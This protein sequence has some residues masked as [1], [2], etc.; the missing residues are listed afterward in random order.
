MRVTVTVEDHT[1]Q[2][3]AAI[4][5]ARTS[6]LMDAGEHL[7]QA[8]SHTIPLEEGVMMGSGVVASDGDGTVAV[9]YTDHPPKLLR[10]HEDVTLNHAPGRRA[11]WLELAGQEQHAAMQAH[12]VD[13]L[14][15]AA[16]GG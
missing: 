5:S 7:L 16:G 8:A 9:G 2:V 3:L 6:S 14:R 15:S 13:A 12:I 10:Q 4:E 1:D 11:K